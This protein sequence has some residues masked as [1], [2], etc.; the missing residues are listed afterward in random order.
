MLAE[1]EQLVGF[2]VAADEPD[3]RGWTVVACNGEEVG[4]VRTLVI[5]T[6]LLKARYFVTQLHCD[7]RVVL[8]PVPLARVDVTTSRVVYDASAAECFNFLPAYP[9]LP[10]CV[11]DDL[12]HVTLIGDTGCQP[13]PARSADR[14]Q[15][16]RRGITNA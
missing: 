2:Q 7:S 13:N 10:T 6:D 12:L 4:T 8:L 15:Q 5:D 16:R 1:L 11:D 9:G 3:P 14:R